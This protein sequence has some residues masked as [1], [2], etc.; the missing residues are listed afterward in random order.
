[1]LRVE[2]ME[3]VNEISRFKSMNS[4]EKERCLNS[5]AGCQVFR[6][7][8]E[9]VPFIIGFSNGLDYIKSSN[10]KKAP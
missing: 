6:T 9:I 2:M 3:I 1:M 8:I 4:E 7:A 5:L 10:V